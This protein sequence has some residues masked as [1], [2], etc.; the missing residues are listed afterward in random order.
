MSRSRRHRISCFQRMTIAVAP[1]ELEDLLLAHPLIRDAAVI[2]IPD[3]RA[4]ELPRAF[5]VRAS[6]SLTEE[7]VKLWIKDKVSPHKQ[8]AG[9][10]EFLREIPKSAAGKIL[11]RVLRERVTS[12]L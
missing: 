2:G 1:A 12:K 3:K 10:V 7:D 11:R 9:G 6:D 5:V 4:G 8:L